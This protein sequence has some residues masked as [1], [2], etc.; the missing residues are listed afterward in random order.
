MRASTWRLIV[1]GPVDGALNMALDRA[2][3]LAR[4]MG[5]V[6]PTLRIYGWTVPTVTLET[7]VG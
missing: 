4:E 1:D 5:A 6:P 7:R 3:Q 2:A